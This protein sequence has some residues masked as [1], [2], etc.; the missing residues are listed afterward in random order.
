MDSIKLGF[1]DQTLNLSLFKNS[2]LYCPLYLNFNSSSK[3]FK[4]K[5][6]GISSYTSFIYS[7]TTQYAV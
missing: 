1:E 2:L 6:N 3:K 4:L 7:N 5:F